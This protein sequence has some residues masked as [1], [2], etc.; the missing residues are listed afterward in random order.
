MLNAPIT[1]RGFSTAA[2]ASVFAPLL[3][4][5][6]KKS[7]PEPQK[8]VVGISSLLDG[9]GLVRIGPGEFEMG[10]TRGNSDEAPVHRVRITRPFEIS[11]YEVTQALWDNVIR[12]AHM[13]PDVPTNFSNFHG[14]TLPVESVTW[15]DVMEFLSRLNAREEQGRVWRL[16]TE[17]EWEYAALGGAGRRSQL[18]P[19]RLGDSAWFEANSQKQTHP[20]GEK[21]PN[22]IGLYDMFG[23]VAEW[24]QDWYGR[25]FYAESPAVD[26]H[27]P[28]TGSYRVYRG[29][30]W[31]DPAK[32]LRASYRGFDL[33][34]NKAYNVGFRVVRAAR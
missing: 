26:P 34:S 8:P 32:N 31:F 22:A 28:D 27:G 24:V 9:T 11:K 23:N 30:C 20:V 14:A 25:D 1:R 33:P 4:G 7:A 6:Q 21:E 12:D 2:A 5:M 16:P 17:A 19:D 13:K 3:I 18:S 15:G 29:G 10:S